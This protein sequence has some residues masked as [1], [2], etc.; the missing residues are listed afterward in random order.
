M[1]AP[2][3]LQARRPTARVLLQVDGLAIGGV[4]AGERHVLV[5]TGVAVA[6]AFVAFEHELRLVLAS[7]KG[8]IVATTARLADA[9]RRALGRRA[10]ATLLGV[11]RLGA[12][13]LVGSAAPWAARPPSAPLVMRP[14]PSFLAPRA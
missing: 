4:V 2:P 10:G 11:R 1:V 3:A 8:L 5:A 7:Y 13:S 6:K 14:W 12:G 9:M